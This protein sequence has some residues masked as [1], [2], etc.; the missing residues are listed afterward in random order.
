MKNQCSRRN[1][2]FSAK[3]KNRWNSFRQKRS[4]EN[5]KRQAGPGIE[6]L[7]ITENV[8]LVGIF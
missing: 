2:A 4:G 1:E 8:A 3:K 6:L 7:G 5:A